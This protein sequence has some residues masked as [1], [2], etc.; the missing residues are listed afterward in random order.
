MTYSENTEGVFDGKYTELIANAALYWTLQ[1]YSAGN[2][3]VRVLIGDNIT[4]IQ[5]GPYKG[6]INSKQVLPW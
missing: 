3:F 6:F 4:I 2:R 1:I 5:L